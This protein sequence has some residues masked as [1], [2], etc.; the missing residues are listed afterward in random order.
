MFAAFQFSHEVGRTLY[1]ADHWIVEWTM[2]LSLAEPGGG[3][4][5]ARVEMLSRTPSGEVA[6]TPVATAEDEE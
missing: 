1:G 6:F 2:V 3:P 4:F 5:T